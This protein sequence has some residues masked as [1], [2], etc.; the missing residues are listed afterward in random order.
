MVVGRNKA[1]DEVLRQFGVEKIY[2]NEED[3]VAISKEVFDGYV[4][5]FLIVWN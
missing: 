1:R 3:I 2:G 5:F 4:F